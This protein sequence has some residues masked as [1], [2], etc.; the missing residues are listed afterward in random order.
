M[1]RTHGIVYV[2]LSGLLMILANVIA[3]IE[4]IDDTNKVIGNNFTATFTDIFCSSM[5]SR[6]PITS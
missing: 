3:N 1:I 6:P 2:N 5:A 4:S